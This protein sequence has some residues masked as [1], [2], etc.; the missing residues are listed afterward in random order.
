MARTIKYIIVVTFL[1]MM[2]ANSAIAEMDSDAF[3]VI[4]EEIFSTWRASNLNGDFDLWLS[5]W[6]E[7]AVKMASN[8]PTLSG[9][10]AIGNLKRKMSQARVVKSWDVEIDEVQLAGDFGYARGTYI[11]SSD[12]KADSTSLTLEG[13]FLTIFRKQADGSWKIYRDCMMAK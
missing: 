6:D 1:V 7:N 5:I 9:K 10:S 3:R 2:M 13:T 11:I 8:R 12:S 4:V